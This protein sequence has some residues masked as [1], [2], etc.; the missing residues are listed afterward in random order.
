MKTT[1]DFEKEIHLAKIQDL[2]DQIEISKI[3]EKELK[4]E[5]KA[6]KKDNEKL[7]K[8]NEKLQEEI[9]RLKRRNELLSKQ[10]LQWLK[11]KNMWKDKYEKKEG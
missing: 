1:Q 3:V 10:A 2:T 5:N 4:S 7:M 8:T 9:I 11:D 6:Q